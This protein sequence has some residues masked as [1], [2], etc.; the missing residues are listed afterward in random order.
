[1]GTPLGDLDGEDFTHTTIKLVNAGDGLSDALRVEPTW[2]RNGDE[3]YCIIKFHVSQVS[4]KPWVGKG[5]DTGLERI[6]TISA[7]AAALADKDL[8][9][10]VIAEMQTRLREL[11]DAEAGQGTLTE[12][13]S[14]VHQITAQG[15]Q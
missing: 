11:R 9:G 7:E 15:A 1:M 5:G 2:L 8:V 14:N 12:E 4:G 10:P 13:L 6:V 3:G